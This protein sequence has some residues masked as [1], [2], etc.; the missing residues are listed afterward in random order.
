MR[1]TFTPNLTKLFMMRKLPMLL[2]LAIMAVSCKKEDSNSQNPTTPTTS[3]YFVKLDDDG[4][5]W[6]ANGAVT[7]LDV[8]ST[9][10]ITGA[11]LTGKSLSIILEKPVAAGSYYVNDQTMSTMS[12][13]R[14]FNPTSVYTTFNFP[15]NGVVHITTAGPT[16]YAGTFEFVG[17]NMNGVTRNFTNGEFKVKVN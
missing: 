3:E 5:S 17:V 14:S 16:E 8:G 15:G 2:L 7:A 9:I 6:S 1:N 11:S 10:Q 12:F 4:K 13:R